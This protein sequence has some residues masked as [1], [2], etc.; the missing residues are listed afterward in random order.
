MQG[1]FY[2]V[3]ARNNQPLTI[4]PQKGFTCVRYKYGLKRTRVRSM[5]LAN[6][7]G[8]QEQMS[9]TISAALVDS[10]F[11]NPMPM[12]LGSF[13]PAIAGSVIA[14]VTGD[15]VSG[16]CV[17]LFL[18]IGMVRALQM[19]RYQQRNAR[20]TVTEAKSWEQQYR[21]GAIAYGVA[22]GIWG[23]TVLLRT[24][25]AAAHMLCVTTVVAYTSAGVGRTFG[26]PQIFHFHLL[27]AIGP[28]ICTLLYVGGAYHTVLALLSFVF[29]VSIRHLTSSLQRIYVNAW[30]AKEREAALADEES[31]Y[32]FRLVVD[33][34]P[35]DAY[36]YRRENDSR[37]NT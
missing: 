8:E 22:L 37:R 20:L 13:G 15:F 7:T 3:Y 11:M 2:S 26:R 14:G 16:L 34:T 4:F 25:D 6:Q 1:D 28:L 10:L 32:R 9:P 31:P 23:A 5:Q 36:S 33:Q 21:I 27:M 24:D 12:I 18:V 19:Y 17:P 30:V 29:F 35:S